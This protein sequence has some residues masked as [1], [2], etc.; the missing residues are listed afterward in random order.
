M[1]GHGSAWLV[2]PCDKACLET[3]SRRVSLPLRSPSRQHLWVSACRHRLLSHH[4]QD[5]PDR[6]GQVGQ[7]IAG[8]AR[9]LFVLGSLATYGTIVI[10]LGAGGGQIILAI[11]VS[12]VL[13]AV[14]F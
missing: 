9:L 7:Q 6:A 10:Y 8:P 3:F 11:V 5:P 12:A 14:G 4:S 2:T 1:I 13:S